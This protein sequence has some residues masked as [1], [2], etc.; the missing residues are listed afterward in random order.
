MGRG[1]F[2][3]EEV[4]EDAAACDAAFRQGDDLNRSLY[5]DCRIQL[6]D[7]YLVKGDR[8]TMATSLEMRNPLL[9]KRLAEFVFSLPGCWKIRQ[10]E[11]K[12]IL[13]RLAEKRVDARCIRRRKRGFGVPLA[14]WIRRELR[15]LFADYLFR[16]NDYFDVGQIRRLYDQH[17]GGRDAHRFT[18]LRVFNFN[19][20]L[21]KYEKG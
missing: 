10:G 3:V 5:L 13:R 21:A 15:E 8:A 11:Q 6:P 16:Q 9:D 19:Y 7:W 12:F 4:F 2:R 1:A 14:R 17:M 18:L 20:W